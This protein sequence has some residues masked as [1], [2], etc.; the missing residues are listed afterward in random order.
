MIVAPFLFIALMLM[1]IL[2]YG[3]TQIGDMVVLSGYILTVITWYSGIAYIIASKAQPAEWFLIGL[4][5]FGPVG[6]LLVLLLPDKYVV[7]EESV[8][9]TGVQAIKYPHWW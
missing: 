7:K 3:Q 4:I 8:K 2:G 6:G 5:P 9:F 1:A